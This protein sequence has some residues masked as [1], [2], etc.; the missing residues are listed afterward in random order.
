MSFESDGWSAESERAQIHRASTSII[1][2]L[3]RRHNSSILLSVLEVKVDRVVPHQS[4]EYLMPLLI[5]VFCLLWL[6]CIVVCVWWTRK[7]KKERERA[8]ARPDESTVNNQLRSPGSPKDNRDKDQ[9]YECRKLMAPPAERTCDGAEAEEEE[10][11]EGEGSEFS[12]VGAGDNRTSLVCTNQSA[13]V[14]APHR[15][16]YSPKDNRCKNLNAARLSEDIKDHYV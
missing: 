6:F 4:I 9:Q 15:T 10:E 5:G 13:A 14:R 1:S 12:R 2:S 11:R 16:K 7:R 3:S 8:A